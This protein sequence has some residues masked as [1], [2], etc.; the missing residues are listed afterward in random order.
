MNLLHP[1]FSKFRR[2]VPDSGPQSYRYQPGPERIGNTPA[3]AGHL[4]GHTAKITIPELCNYE[5]AIRH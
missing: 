5:H 1:V 2:F 4:V 3:F